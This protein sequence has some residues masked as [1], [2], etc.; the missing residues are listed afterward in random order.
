MTYPRTV[1]ASW[2]LAILLACML[3]Y[4]LAHAGQLSLDLKGGVAVP[5]RTTPDGTY[6]QEALPHNTKLATPAYAIGLSYQATPTLSFQAHYL[7]LG[8]SRINGRAVSDENYD[9]KAHKCR[10]D[11]SSVY[12]YNFQATDSL[13][14]GDLTATYTWQGEGVRPFVKGGL[15]LLYHQARFRNTDT[16]DI[17][18]F[19]GWIPALELGAGLAY[20]WAYV[21]L[22]YFRGMNFGGQN[23]PI[24]T[25]QFA[26]FAGVK[27]GLF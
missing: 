6:W 24:S 21:E 10:V 3:A 19:N 25:Q 27:I 8:S 4:D 5:M 17:D 1:I 23:L 7:N 9:H 22:D 12:Q 13:K 26:L 14:G 16:G 20:Q 2:L 18:R 15:A 11:C